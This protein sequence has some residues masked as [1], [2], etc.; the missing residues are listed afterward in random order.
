M[1]VWG[2]SVRPPNAN[3]ALAA[4]LLNA[5]L[6]GR[7][8]RRFLERTVRP[9]QTVVDVGANLGVFTLLLSRL[10]GPSGR[11]V[12]LEPE[13]DLFRALDENCRRNGAHQVTRVRAAA[14]DRQSRGVLH[15]SRFNSG[16]NRLSGSWR[17]ATIPVEIV[18]IDETVPHEPV[19]FVKIDVQGYELHV[20]RGMQ[21]LVDRSPALQV[22]FEFWPAGLGYA[23][24]APG[25]LLEFFLDRGFSL[26]ELSGDGLR[27]VSRDDVLQSI[28]GR[29]W[30]WK[31]L[32]ASREDGIAVR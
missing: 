22:L 23:G 7:S 4:G 32:L 13:P 14:G 25:D 2:F 12:A 20:V 31:N 19:G 17:G 16:D 21:A 11:V 15:C 18:T 28:T 26:F 24:S 27:R 6:I 8:E 30:S 9:G 3:R 1:N 10:V 29:A 5:G